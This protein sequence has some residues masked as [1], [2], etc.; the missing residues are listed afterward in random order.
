MLLEKTRLSQFPKSMRTAL[1]CGFIASMACAGIGAADTATN[2][3]PATAASARLVIVNAVYGNLSDPT[4]TTNVTAIVA[5]LVDGDALD[6]HPDNGIFGGDPA[7]N[8]IKQLKVDYT[9]DGVTGTK[10]AFESGRLRI[11]AN[12]NPGAAKKSRLVIHKAVYGNLPKGKAS[13]VTAIIADMV[14]NDALEVTANNNNFGDPASGVVKKLRVDYTFD[15]W[16]KTIT[17]GENETLKISP[18]VEQAENRKRILIFSLWIVCGIM[19]V[20]A[21]VAAAVLLTRKWKKA[22][23]EAGG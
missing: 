17:I 2:A 3:V 21:V 5:A 19:A 6:M 23:T 22:G 7:P 10:T 15:G 1:L 18:N 8:V 13:N 4:A 11:S 12:V 16:K 20:S 14:E 9:I